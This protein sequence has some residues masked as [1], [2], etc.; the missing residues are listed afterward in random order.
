MSE[1]NNARLGDLMS[2]VYQHFM[3][4]YRDANLASIAAAAVI[5]E[6]M[7]QPDHSAWVQG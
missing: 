7:R 2:I 3:E 5:D 6:M 1:N 4:E